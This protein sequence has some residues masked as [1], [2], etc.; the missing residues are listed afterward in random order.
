[1]TPAIHSCRVIVHTY[2]LTCFARFTLSVLHDGPK[3]LTVRLCSAG[4]RHLP[5]LPQPG[6][7]KSGRRQEMQRATAPPR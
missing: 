3:S 4:T 5:I 2:Y 1:M 6:Y 7:R